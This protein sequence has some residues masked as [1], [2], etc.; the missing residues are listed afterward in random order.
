MLFCIFRDLFDSV[1]HFFMIFVTFFHPSWTYAV[2]LQISFYPVL[3]DVRKFPKRAARVAASALFFLGIPL[4]SLD[5]PRNFLKFLFYLCP[6]RVNFCAANSNTFP[7][8]AEGA[9]N[10]L[11][12]LPPPFSFSVFPFRPGNLGLFGALLLSPA[13]EKKIGDIPAHFFFFFFART[14]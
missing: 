5:Y 2:A 6:T 8:Q 14:L 7:G 1:P 9:A 12:R 13:P 10:P 11:G 3:A 4:K